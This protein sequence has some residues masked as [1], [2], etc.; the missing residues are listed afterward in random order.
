MRTVRDGDAAGPL[1]PSVA[2]VGVFDGLHRGHQAVI[3][4]LRSLAERYGAPATVVT[5]DPL[6]AAILTPDAAPR[7]LATLDQRLEGLEA[8]GVDQVR[9]LTFDD[10]LARESATA[11]VE[12]VLVGELGVRCV[13]VGED[14]RFGHDRQGSVAL[15]REC[16]ERLG[17]DVAPAPLAGDGERW[18]STSVRRALE[19]GDLAGARAILGHAFTLRGSVVH[20]DQRGTELGF[21]T[22]NLALGPYQQLPEDGV[23]AGAARVGE[24]WLAA[25][26]SV[27]TRPHFYDR[28]EL[29]VEVYL[30]DFEGDLYAATLDVAFLARLR[31]QRVFASDEELGERIERDVAE[32]RAVFGKLSPLDLELLG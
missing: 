16:G 6:P 14:F 5:F 26:V 18:S 10:A 1:S 27:G 12:R 8:L 9:L 22:A 20:G 21:P 7:L 25:A 11:F 31:E 23:Y 17:F 4:Q 3:A 19:R 2:A 29:L 32:T 30:L 24:R 28:G 15:L 13:V